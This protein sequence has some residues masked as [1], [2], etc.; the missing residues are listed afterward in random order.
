MFIVQEAI[1]ADY[2]SSHETQEEAVE[3]IDEL[4]Q[5]GLASP[6]DFNIREIDAGGRIV[7]VIDIDDP[8]LTR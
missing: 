4:I 7:R 5:A 6:G 1:H 8:P 3:A 2:V